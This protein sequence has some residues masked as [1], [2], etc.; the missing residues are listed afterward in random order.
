M[1]LRYSDFTTRTVSR[2]VGIASD[3]DAQ[4]L[5]V[6]ID[7]LT[8]VWTPGAGLRLLGFGVSNFGRVTQQLDLLNDIEPESK[9]H[10]RSLVE[11]L[12]QIKERFGDDVLGFGVRGIRVPKGPDT[13]VK[14]VD[15]DAS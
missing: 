3:V 12:D 5:P 15:D 14:G 6:A 10:E 11:G 1:K 7:L 13:P 4:I 9:T 8:E 2:T